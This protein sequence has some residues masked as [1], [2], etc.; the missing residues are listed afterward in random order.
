VTIACLGLFALATFAAQERLKEIGI[1]K[2]LGASVASISALF[3][4]DFL[5][6]ILVAVGIASPLAWWAM[7]RWLEHFA[8][9]T[10][11]NWWIFPAA[12]AVLLVVAQLTVLFRTTKA[13]R[14]NPTVN[15]RNE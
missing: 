10:P 6:P 12:G 11:I 1:R 13:A 4:R 5:L 15:L 2:V 7:H 9:R 14:V 8:Y 3:S